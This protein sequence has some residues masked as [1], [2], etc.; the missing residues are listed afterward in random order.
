[1]DTTKRKGRGKVKDGWEERGEETEGDEKER[2]GERK[3]K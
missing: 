2:Q 1:M 3:A